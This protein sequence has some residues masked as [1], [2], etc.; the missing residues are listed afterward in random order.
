MAINHKNTSTHHLP[1]PG[2]ASTESPSSDSANVVAFQIESLQGGA[3]PQ[4][5]SKVLCTF[6]CNAIVSVNCTN[7]RG[8][9]FA[10]ASSIPVLPRSRETSAGDSRSTPTR[11]ADP[12]SSRSFASR[13]RC[14]SRLHCASTPA[15]LVAPSGPMP[16]VLRLSR[17]SDPPPHQPP[18]NR[19]Q[20]TPQTSDFLLQ[21]MVL[22]LGAQMLGAGAN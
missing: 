5:S 1:L 10:P 2:L 12:A 9:L 13:L 19:L 11:L 6:V 18:A 8:R 14:V 17:L 7:T 21:T 3:L 15:R 22:V 20:T 4:H 16:L